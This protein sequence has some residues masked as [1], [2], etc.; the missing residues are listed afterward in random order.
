[1]S[2]YKKLFVSFYKNFLCSYKKSYLCHSIKIYL[3]RFIKA[4]CV[5]I[6]KLFLSFYKN[7]LCHFFAFVNRIFFLYFYKKK[8]FSRSIINMESFDFKDLNLSSEESKDI[9]EFLARKRG[10]NIYKHK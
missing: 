5:L 1:M 8:F 6:K 3:C 4:V 10:V 2:F 7:Y 9:I